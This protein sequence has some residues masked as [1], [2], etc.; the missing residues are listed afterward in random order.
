MILRPLVAHTSGSGQWA[1]KLLARLEVTLPALDWP[2]RARGRV[3]DLRLV[4][5][6]VD[7]YFSR[8]ACQMANQNKMSQDQQ[9]RLRSML[10]A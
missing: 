6:W 7:F 8:V 9:M 3:K 10:L 1:R 5:D 4:G 2:A